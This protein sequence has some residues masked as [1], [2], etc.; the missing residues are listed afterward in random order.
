MP[1]RDVIGL[2]NALVDLQ[3]RVDHSFLQ[4]LGIAPGSMTLVDAPTQQRVLAA[5]EGRAVNRCSGGSA[6]NTIA[7]LAELGSTAA[8][9]CRVGEDP[10]G[11]FYLEDLERLGVKVTGGSAGAPTGT[12]VVLITPDA[13]RT[14]LTNLGVSAE[15]APEDLD[16]DVIA[17]ARWLY[18]EGY[19]LPGEATRAAM[20]AAVE[21]AKRHGVKVALSASD[22]FCIETCRDLVW[23]LVDG[24][25]D[26]LFCNES[27]GRALTGLDDPIA[28]AHAIHSHATSVALTY[29]ANGSILV[30]EREVFPIEGVAVEA[31]DT[32][33]AGDMYAAGIL[34]GLTQGLSWPVA[35]RLASHAAARVVAHLGARLPRRFTAAELEELRRPS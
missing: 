2:G 17:S 14:L 10:L 18:V 22:P 13:Q 9:C 26:L 5:L 20:L 30:H 32:T 3:V 25:V 16:E 4:E 11:A 23:S 19:L 28:A 33:G 24:P 35:G 7:G 6:A 27:E 29:G 34:H 1:Q 21:I 12:C 15:L 31:L 8:Y